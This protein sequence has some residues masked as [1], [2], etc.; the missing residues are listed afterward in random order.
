MRWVGSHVPLGLHCQR[1]GGSV[2]E[3][4]QRTANELFVGID[5]FNSSDSL[6]RRPVVNC[7]AVEAPLISQFIG[8]NF[9]II[10]VESVGRTKAT[11][12]TY[13]VLMY[14][15]QFMGDQESH[16]IVRHPLRDRRPK[17]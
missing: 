7:V 5:H 17:S 12:V 14:M 1:L 10:R 2:L 11:Y 15:R 6:L 8:T 9:D 13:R 16:Y 4:G 3:V